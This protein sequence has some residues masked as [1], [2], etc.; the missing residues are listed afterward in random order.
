MQ[1]DILTEWFLVLHQYER[2]SGAKA[3]RFRVRMLKDQPW[4][5]LKHK[6]TIYLTLLME[7]AKK[8]PPLMARPLRGRGVKA[9]PLREKNLF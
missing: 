3:T 9:S 5:Y 6:P 2:F 1:T 7:A 8:V 4:K